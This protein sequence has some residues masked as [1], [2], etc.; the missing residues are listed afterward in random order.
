MTT[1]SILAAVAD[2][3]QSRHTIA[4]SVHTA[5]GDTEAEVE[6]YSV[7]QRRWAPTFYCWDIGLGRIVGLPLASLHRGEV[8]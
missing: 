8:D 7:I 2:A 6:P 1:E 3:A 5:D 4:V